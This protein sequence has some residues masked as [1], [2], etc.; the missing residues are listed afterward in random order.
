MAIA[1]WCRSCGQ[2]YHLAHDLAGQTV[3]CTTCGAGVPVP[4]PQPTT[5]GRPPEYGFLPPAARHDMNGP[6]PLLRSGSRRRKK[7][8]SPVLFA[9]LGI[10]VVGLLG[11]VVI[12]VIVARNIVS[13]ARPVIAEAMSATAPPQPVVA[14]GSYH[15]ASFSSGSG[16]VV[17]AAP[18]LPAV[19][20][21][22]APSSAE[23]V[24]KRLLANLN[25]LNGL[26]AQIVDRASADRLRDQIPPKVREF[27]DLGYR[28]KTVANRLSRA[29]DQRLQSLYMAQL[30]SGLEQLKNHATRLNSLGQQLRMDELN[31]HMAELEARSRDMGRMPQP[32]TFQPPVMPPP[33]IQPPTMRPPVMQ[34]PTIPRPPVMQPPTIPRPPRPSMPHGMRPPSMPRRHGR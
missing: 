32:P 28:L 2:A 9:G 24:I 29:E 26:L 30:N 5:V 33:A 22:P 25:E 19:N 18:S 12:V 8:P 16:T 20:G 21:S 7:G 17:P 31:R 27:V 6:A 34:P 11:M 1:V 23:D 10:A 13:A 14:S 4:V 15:P 3:R